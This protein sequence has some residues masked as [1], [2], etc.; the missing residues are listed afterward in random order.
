MD[1]YEETL[2][3]QELYWELN[4]VQH[5]LGYVQQYG[6]YSHSTLLARRLFNERTFTD[7]CDLDVGW[8]Y[9]NDHYWKST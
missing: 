7:R 4:R 5:I 6:S 3:E 9:F 2:E 1:N 8:V